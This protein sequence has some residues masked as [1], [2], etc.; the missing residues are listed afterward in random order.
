MNIVITGASKGIGFE[1]VKLAVA[2][3]NKV[4]AISRNTD[5]LKELAITNSQNL[6]CINADLSVGS[7]VLKVKNEIAL[8]VNTI[9]VLI[10]NAGA[11]VNKP[12]SEITND[13]LNKVYSTNVFAPFLLTQKLLPFIE[14]STI[15]HIVNISSMG[16]VGGTSKFAGLSAY[17]SSKGAL[18]I[19]TECL[20]EEFKPQNIIVNA[21]A[22]GAVNTEMLQNAFPGYIATTQASE[23]SEYIYK[24]ATEHYKFYNGKV[25]P[26]SSSTP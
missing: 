8:Q 7:D 17:S 25:L 22:L 18:S 19:L 26:V 5:S 12:F 15:K 9:D 14:K 10:N 20:A 23:M 4:F 1:L 2:N 21:L 3:N 6:C 24:F 11:L 13:D 16:G